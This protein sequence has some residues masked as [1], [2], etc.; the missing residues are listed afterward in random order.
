MSDNGLFLVFSNP[1]EGR[2]SEF[3]EW[4]DTV[5]APE[6][7]AIP[8]IVS[9]QRFDLEE[10]AV[11]EGGAAP[12]PPAHRYL[13]VYEV[14]G[15]VGKILSSLADGATSGQVNMS[16]SLDTANAA[17]SFWKPRGPKVT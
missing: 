14:E 15:D 17:I 4:Y 3:N 11:P 9:A 16:D 13:T 5:H 1:V 2:E 12:P 10:P 8:G 7:L 6:V